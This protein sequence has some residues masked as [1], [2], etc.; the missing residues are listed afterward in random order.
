MPPCFDTALPPLI[1]IFSIL[2][3]CPLDRSSGS[4]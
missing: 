2:I 1:L 4:E 3:F